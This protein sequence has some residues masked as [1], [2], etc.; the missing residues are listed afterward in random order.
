M[1][2]K[3]SVFGGA[4][5][6]PES[7]AYQEAYHLGKLLGGVGLTVLTGGY[8]G[9]MEA[10]SRGANEAGAHV[11]GITSDEIEACR[12]IGPNQWVTEEWRCKTFRDR[13]DQL[14]ENC[15]A[16]IALPGGIG[17]LV[18]IGLTWNHLVLH[19]IDPKPLILIG[20]GWHKIMKLFFTELGDYVSIANRKY[21]TFAPNPKTTLEVLSSFSII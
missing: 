6:K 5:P 21:L 4:N 19:T 15:D 14:V 3:I 7:Q 17:T 10:V 8:T 12:P 18:E 1:T 11:I 13:L 9:T 20:N 16:A 2:R